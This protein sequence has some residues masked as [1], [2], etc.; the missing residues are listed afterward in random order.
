MK[1]SRTWLQK[2]FTDPL[3]EADVISDALTFH[4]AEVEEVTPEYF[5][6][7]IL[8][9]RAAYMLS[10]RGVALELA[11]AL[12]VPLAHDPLR[13]EVGEFPK[14]DAVSVSIE[15][16]TACTRYMAG[17]V[18]GV[19]VGP[20]P[21]WLKSALESIGQRSIN[22]VVDATNYVMLNVGQP[23]H[24]FDAN[25]ISSENGTHA[26]AIRA[27]TEGEKIT[28]LTGDE[29][30]LSSTTLLITDGGTGAP[31]G[32]AGVKGGK[33]AQI[34]DATTDLI[35]ESANFD[36]TL[37]R[38]TSQAL[39]LW[40][41]A[42]LRFQNRPSPVLASYAMRDV[43][44][45]IT[46]I[47]GG[48]LVGVVDAYPTLSETIPVT[49]SV[50]KINARLG[51]SFVREDV[52]RVFDTLGFTYT[53]AEGTFTV[54]PPF[55]RRDIVIGED[56]AE[57]VGRVVGYDT[58]PATD[59]PGVPQLP[60]QSEFRGIERV[61]DF[62]V[63]RGFIEVST[64]SFGTEGD[65]KLEN[66]LQDDR[67]WLRASLLPTLRD[68]LVRAVQ[69]APRVLGPAPIV[70]VFE[71]GNTFTKDGEFLL[72]GLAAR[73]LE[74]KGA[75]EALKEYAATI[76]QELLQSPG[77]T[78]FS[79]DGKSVE[80]VLSYED[81][82]RLGADYEPKKA[83]LGA[84]HSFS[85]YPFALRDIAVWTP[86][87]TQSDSV[88]ELITKEAGELLLRIDQF[89][90]FEKEGRVSYAFR[91]VFESKEKTLSDADLNP[92]MENVTA[93]LNAQ[94]GFEVR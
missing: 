64:Q 54:L 30:E 72:V 38:R 3:P 42:S 48:E 44:A 84:Y 82:E 66:P 76:Q 87:G 8:P 37:V 2:Y 33:L 57:E 67:P 79:L 45:L 7:K 15:D 6:V 36:G 70:K 77:H 26:V 1:I 80:V 60:N 83:V 23:L 88:A 14:T 58:I 5:D 27:A 73:A 16:E 92:V 85:V 40:T 56:L 90:S 94:G 20:S 10:H 91:L 93:T 52:T 39:K 24:A 78:H 47:A 43:I 89:D 13:E 35:I 61:K 50:E 9:D 62:L 46:D 69:N 63:E 4:V 12:G 31:L 18:R 11:A 86:A 19:H 21:E 41:D 34:D 32:I 25:K 71:V 74:G 28:S 29:Y 68:A 17:L 55:E 49:T 75:E 22:N 65:I 53:E 59:L 81:L 51:S